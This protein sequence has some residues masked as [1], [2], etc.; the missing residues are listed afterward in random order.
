VTHAELLEQIVRSQGWLLEMLGA[1][2]D[3]E[4][5]DGVIAAGCIRNTVWDVLHD[6]EPSTDFNDVDVMFCDPALERDEKKIDRELTA[7]L[8]G[9]EWQAKN[10]ATI[11]EWYLRKLGVDIA[12]LTSTSAGLAGFVETATAVGV[13]LESDDSLTIL[14]PLGLD[15][16]FG[17]RLRVNEISPDPWYFEKRVT[18]KGWLQRWPR[19]T[20]VDG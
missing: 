11:H 16:L 4:L 12:P 10:Q 13:R 20:L 8:P 1:V 5:P 6:R 7:L 9:Y 18:E 14:A 19:L 3:L 15:D 17:L 2:R